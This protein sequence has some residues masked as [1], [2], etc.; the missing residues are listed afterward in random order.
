MLAWHY[1]YACPLRR[2]SRAEDCNGPWECPKSL[3]QKPFE[4]QVDLRWKT[5]PHLYCPGCG[6]MSTWT[7]QPVTVTV[8]CPICHSIYGVRPMRPKTP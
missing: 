8:M 5:E 4:V 1:C 2:D 6:Y 7:P 3:A